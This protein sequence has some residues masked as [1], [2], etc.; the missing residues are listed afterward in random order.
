MTGSIFHVPVNFC[1]TNSIESDLS[2]LHHGQ[3]QDSVYTRNMMK[4]VNSIHE[5]LK[6]RETFVLEKEKEVNSKMQL[7]G[8]TKFNAMSLEKDN[9]IPTIFFITPTYK[10]L[11]QK[12][13]LTRLSQ[14]LLHVPK[15]HWILVEDSHEKTNL[16]QRFLAGCGVQFSHLAVRTPKQLITKEGDPRWL[17]ARGV[18]QRNLGLKWIRQNYKDG[19]NGVIYFGDDDNTYDLKIFE[20]MRYTK[21][22]SVWPVGL[23]GGLKWEG[24]ICKDGSVVKFYTLWKPQRPMPLDMAGFAINAKL[25]ID[26]PNVEMDTMAARGY[27]ESSVVSRLATREEFEPL[28]NNCKEI[29]VW[30]TQT[31]EPKMKQEDRLKKMGFESD[32]SMEV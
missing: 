4:R 19:M 28:A 12:A 17:K 11:T 24:P 10:R 27:L 30:H 29:L 13:D 18:E 20:Q 25:I 1:G 3:N 9:Q 7:L 21:K 2:E 8:I 6:K 15:L 23:V 14:T 22:I 26:N 5:S 16:V 32:P 31:A